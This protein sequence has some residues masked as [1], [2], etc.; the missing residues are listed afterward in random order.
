MLYSCN[1]GHHNR[2]GHRTHPH[3]KFNLHNSTGTAVANLLV[4]AS[5]ASESKSAAVFL[6]P[7]RSIA[8]EPPPA[9]RRGR[10]QHAGSRF[11]LPSHGSSQAPFS[12]EQNGVLIPKLFLTVSFLYSA[13]PLVRR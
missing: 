2:K 3:A 7:P 1:E 11:Q 10:H 9:G 6:V 13:V 4:S 8:P 12:A 5:S